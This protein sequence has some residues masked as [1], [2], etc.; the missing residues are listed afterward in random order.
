LTKK[1]SLFLGDFDVK[2]PGTHNPWSSAP[3]KIAPFDHEFY[4]SIG[5]A[6][7]SNFFAD[8]FVNDG[9]VAEKPW[10]NTSVSAARDFWHARNNWLS[11]WKINENRTKEASFLIDYIRIWAL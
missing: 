7:G 9:I 11:T 1:T 10:N 8:N 5:L 4:V 2:I 3:N 6:V